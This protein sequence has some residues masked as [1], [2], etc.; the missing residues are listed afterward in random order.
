[1]QRR[2]RRSEQSTQHILLRSGEDP[3]RIGEQCLLPLSRL[4]N[5]RIHRNLGTAFRRLLPQQC[6]KISSR[7]NADLTPRNGP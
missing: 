5:L 7:L 2:G 1:M 3:Q 6:G 4:E